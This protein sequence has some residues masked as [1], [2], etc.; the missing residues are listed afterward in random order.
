[1]AG[2]GGSNP[3]PNPCAT[4][5]LVIK[6]GAASSIEDANFP[7]AQAWDGDAV[8]RWASLKTEPHWIYVDLGEVAHVSRVRLMWEAAYATVYDIERANAAGGPWTSM[9]HVTNGNGG[10]DD[11]TTLTAGNGRYIRMNGITRFTAYGF[12]LFE[13]EVY[14]DLDEA[15]D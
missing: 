5:K 13:I 9:Q 2:T 12:S 6:G 15:C 10:T 4:G 8:T 11:L 1:M 3:Q 7:A 14:G